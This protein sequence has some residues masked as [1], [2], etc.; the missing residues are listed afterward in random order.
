M[1]A[2]AVAGLFGVSVLHGQSLPA[3]ARRPV[4]AQGKPAKVLSAN[5]VIV[6]AAKAH[7]T[8]VKMRLEQQKSALLSRPKPSAA[9]SRPFPATRPPPVP[10]R[11]RH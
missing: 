2:I 11:Y 4:N 6:N 10:Q 9:A 7:N 8:N 1:L 5:P 3:A